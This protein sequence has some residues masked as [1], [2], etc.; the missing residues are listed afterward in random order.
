MLI[1][2]KTLVRLRELINEET[3]YRSGPALVR[4]FN[5]LG[6]SDVYGKGFPSRW[7]YTEGAWVT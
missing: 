5:E 4:F 3:E 7:V 1:Q 2:N 6:F